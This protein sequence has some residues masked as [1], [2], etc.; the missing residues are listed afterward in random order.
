MKYVRSLLDYFV[1]GVLKSVQKLGDKNIPVYARFVEPNVLEIEGQKIIAEAVVIAAG[2]SPVVPEPWWDFGD[3]VI[4]T[5]D[6]FEAETLADD[7][8][9]IGGGV[10]GLELGQAL[11]RM[12]IIIEMTEGGENIGGISDPTVNRYAVETLREE[13]NLFLGQAAGLSL[14]EDRLVLGRDGD[15]QEFAQTLIAVGRSPN[16][17]RLGLEKIGVSLDEKRM[18]EVDSSTLRIQDT[19]IFLAGDVNGY[20]PF[21]HEVA[22]EGR[23][24]GYNAIQ[25]EN[26][27]FKRRTPPTVAFTKPQIVMAGKRYREIE[28]SPHVAGEENFESLGRARILDENRGI[29][30]V[31]AEPR[32]GKLLG[33]E[34]MALEGE[35]LGH[36]LA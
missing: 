27:C 22:D 36:L 26:R 9:V 13:F 15:S 32:R 25:V 8:A 2:S 3:R 19:P 18:P 17:S 28:Q 23:V 7:M 10:N 35:Y 11:S 20:R 1:S 6:I 29:L 31:Y 34:M 33:A 14:K 21:L 12:G 4:T 16:I 24:A 5:D 30:R